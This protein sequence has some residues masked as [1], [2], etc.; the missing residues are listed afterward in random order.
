L[1]TIWIVPLALVENRDVN[2]R[3][4]CACSGAASDMSSTAAT[5]ILMPVR[6]S[7]TPCMSCSATT[8]I[9]PSCWS[10]HTGRAAVRTGRP[11]YPGA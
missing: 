5:P 6:R 2:V 7:F 8:R 10:C 1:P 11:V 9:V 4:I 3:T